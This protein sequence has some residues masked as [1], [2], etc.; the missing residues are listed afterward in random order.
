MRRPYLESYKVIPKRNY[1]GAL[2]Y[3]YPPPNSPTNEFSTSL[4]S[5]S[6]SHFNLERYISYSLNPA[7]YPKVS[8]RK[9]LEPQI[10]PKAYLE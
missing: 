6:E 7:V 2:G 10:Y 1:Y 3:S 4:P 9:I 8:T 5:K